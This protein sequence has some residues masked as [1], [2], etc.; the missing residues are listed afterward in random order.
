MAL[1]D[2]IS[3]LRKALSA[4]TCV[5]SDPSNEDFRL[6]LLRW[7]DV[8]VKI[9]GAI[10]QVSNESDAVKT[11][12]LASVHRTPFVPVC[13]GHSLWSTIGTDGFILDLTKYKSIHVDAAQHEVTVAGGVLMKEFATALAN[14][15]ECAPVGNGNTIGVI[16]YFLGG[17]IGVATGLMGIACDNMRSAKVVLASGQLVIADE[18]HHSELFWAIKGAGY[19]FG[20]I[21]EI[22]LRT[23]PLSVF[24][25]PEGQ[26]W[27]GNYLY[28][29]ERAAEVFKVV[30]SLVATSGSRTAGLVMLIAPPPHHKPVIAVVP[31]YFGNLEDGPRVFQELSKL[32]PVIYSEKSPHVPNLSDHLD[33]ACGKGGLRRFN[34][35]GLQEFRIENCLQLTNV[36][37]QLLES[38]PDA[39]TSGYFVEWHCLPPP[40]LVTNSAFSH[41]TV[42]IW[43][44]CLSWCQEETSLPKVFEFEA[45]AID[46]M[47]QGTKP[48]NYID[49][50]H[51]TRTH[52]IERRFPDQDILTKLRALKK[53]FDPQGMFT[54]E[55]L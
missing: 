9:P 42:H 2:F 4:E 14:A 49:L 46:A 17:G 8:D 50:P 25:T 44:H 11:V 34:L 29:M 38:C 18:K 31:H 35:T 20:L 22:T 43:L 37:Q 40:D 7:S 47:R 32:G 6:A 39:T 27:I 45:R 21:L 52:P 1:T 13:G 3:E 23:Y 15:G 51:G 12:K 30:E 41:E 48:E 26:H 5:L 24:G 36:F 55:L 33:F 10:V 53:E 28:P 16:P 54:R 19:Y